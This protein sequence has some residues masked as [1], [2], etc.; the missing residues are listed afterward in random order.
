MIFQH[1]LN[2]FRTESKEKHQPEKK[3]ILFIVKKRCLPFY[4]NQG[5]EASTGLLNSAK[6]VV[7]MINT[8]IPSAIAHIEE[9]QDNNCIDRVVTAFK[10]DIVIL[11]ALWMI[12]SKLDVLNK[13]HP[14]VKWI[15]RLHSD[16][17]FLAHEG[18]AI[19]W[20]KQYIINGAWIGVNSERIERELNFFLPKNY[21]NYLPNFYPLPEIDIS[22]PRW[23][24]DDLIDIGCFGA[25]RPMKNQLMQALVAIRFAKNQGKRL[26]F[27]INGSRCESK[28]ENVLRNL[29]ALFADNDSCDLIEHPWMPHNEFLVL[30]AQMDVN[31]QVSL[32][33]TFNIVAADSVALGVPVCVSTEIDWVYPKFQANPTCSYSIL[34]TLELAYSLARS[35]K[36]RANY[37]GLKKYNKLTREAWMKLLS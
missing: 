22:R 20:I 2:F 21:I 25:I 29:Q 12:P 4:D 17:P 27:H 34:E 16:A 32:S 7:D 23:Q 10:P 15:I 9:V 11:E 14:K 8:S 24:R 28:G 31:M 30:I 5:I 33:E 1:V 18:V 26:R 19:D 35:G 3:R 36:H 13:L 37:K 6:F